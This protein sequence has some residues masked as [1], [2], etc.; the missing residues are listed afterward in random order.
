MNSL[1]FDITMKKITTN[2]K[3]EISVTLFVPFI[4]FTKSDENLVGEFRI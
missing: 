4:R 3:C 2:V 1:S